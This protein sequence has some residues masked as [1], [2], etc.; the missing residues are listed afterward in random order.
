MEGWLIQLN[1]SPSKEV[2]QRN[3]SPHSFKR[4]LS[5]ELEN[6]S[7]NLFRRKESLPSESPG[8]YG[9]EVRERKR[10]FEMNKLTSAI[11]LALWFGFLLSGCGGGNPSL[12]ETREQRIDQVIQAG[13]ESGKIVGL[14]VAVVR[15]NQLVFAKGYGFANIDQKVKA[16]ERTSYMLASSSKPVTAVL[17]LQLVDAKKLNLDTDINSYLSFRVQNPSHPD[18]GI[19]LRHLLSHVSSIRETSKVF[20][21][22]LLGL[23]SKNKDSPISL[24]DFCKGYLT[25]EGKYFDPSNYSS[26][27]PQTRYIYSNVGYGLIGHLAERVSGKDFEELSQTNLFSRLKMSNTSWKLSG[28][29]KESSSSMYK[30]ERNREPQKVAPYGF[31]DYPSGSLKSSAVEMT[32]FLQMLLN[33]GMFAG[34]RILSEASVREMERVQYPDLS[35]YQTLGMQRTTRGTLRFYHEGSET[36]ATALIAYTPKYKMGYV[37]LANSSGEDNASEQAIERAVSIMG[38]TLLREFTQRND[39]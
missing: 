10:V 32:N 34:Q 28:V 22:I 4:S 7:L 38:D 16:T 19:T 31:P 26:V 3:R 18:K 8:S 27:A 2:Y 12:P 5:D 6:D 11:G 14:S 37:I 13:L 9:K 25:P 1:S 15:E 23:Y 30:V 33:R 29:K 24:L 36:G 21:Q 20:E 39:P 17:A 35:R